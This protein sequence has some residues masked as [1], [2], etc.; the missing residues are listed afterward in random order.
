MFY[1]SSLAMY[2]CLLPFRSPDC[3]HAFHNNKISQAGL[4]VLLWG[5]NSE[6]IYY[7]GSHVLG[8][9]DYSFCT[10]MIEIPSDHLKDYTR[11]SVSMRDGGL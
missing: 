2:T 4:V 9:Q 6:A 5:H 7:K 8:L 11:I 10:Q 1:R 3:A